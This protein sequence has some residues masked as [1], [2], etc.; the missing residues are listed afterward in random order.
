MPTT[1][2]FIFVSAFVSTFALLY[3]STS[4]IGEYLKSKGWDI[5]DL[6]LIG[7][8]KKDFGDEPPPKMLS[9]SDVVSAIKQDTGAQ[10]AAVAG[11]LTVVFVLAKALKSSE[12]FVFYLS[13]TLEVSCISSFRQR[14]NR[15]WI[16]MNGK[17]SLSRRSS[18]FLPIRR[19]KLL[20]PH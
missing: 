1:S 4:Y 2:Q 19:C 17:N 16:L 18:P 20:F 5:N 8:E 14:R 7:L 13:R 9:F 6:I 10:A 12:F 3:V 15:Y 11:L